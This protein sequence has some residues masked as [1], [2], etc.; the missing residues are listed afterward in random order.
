MKNAWLQ[1]IRMRIRSLNK[2]TSRAYSFTSN[3]I[4]ATNKQE[5]CVSDRKTKN[6]CSTRGKGCR[7]RS[8]QVYDHASSSHK[9]SHKWEQWIK[10]GREIQAKLFRLY[11]RQ[12]TESSLRKKYITGFFSSES[13]PLLHQTNIKRNRRSSLKY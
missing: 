10:V 2:W 12:I 3:I 4:T 7:Q 9:A 5:K 1:N 6:W 13:R 8:V 11:F